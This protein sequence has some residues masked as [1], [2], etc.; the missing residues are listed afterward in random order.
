[1]KRRANISKFIFAILS[2]LI[3]ANLWGQTTSSL[4]KG[5]GG[6]YSPWL[7]ESAA[8]WEIFV[9]DVN[10]LGYNYSGKYVQLT[11]NIGTVS[12]PITSMVGVWSDKESLRKPFSGIFSGDNFILTVRYENTGE[13]TA[14]FQCTK[15]ATIKLLAVRGDIIT[16]EGYAA[17]LIGGN[18]GSKT[19]VEN[20]VMVS[21]NIT[22]GNNG[23]AGDNCA[24][25]VVDGT[26]V[27]I[28]ATVYN[29]M[30]KAN[31][32]CGGFI[33]TGSNTNP[34]YT[35]INNSLFAPAEGTEMVY[36]EN[37]VANNTYN[38]L[39]TS[40]YATQIGES[41][42]GN[43]AYASYD[44]VP[45]SGFW[46]KKTLHDGEDY[47][48][49]GEGAIVG[50]HSEYYQNN[51][52]NGGFVYTV[53]F[54]E[55]DIDAVDVDPSYYTAVIL[56]DESPIT[57]DDIRPGDYTLKITGNTGYC[58]G[59]KNAG[60]SVLRSVF[61]YGSGT[62]ADPYQI[63][64]NT[65]WNILANA[66][67]DGH[68]FDGEYLKLMNDITLTINNSVG[69]D[70][71]VG[72]SRNAS[73]GPEDK[74]F[75]GTFDGDWHTLT[76]NVGSN[77]SAYK[78][79]HQYFP[80]APFS[81]IDGATIKNLTVE[82]KIYA[83]NKYNSG[84]VGY[85]FNAK[86]S[87]A[88]Y[89]INCTSSINIDCSAIRGTNPDCSSSGFVAENKSGSI[90]FTNCIF[91][92]LIDK[93][94]LSAAQKCAGFVSYNGGSKLF[95]TNCTMA[96]I[97]TLTGNYATF[98]R[99]GSAE[100]S[101]AYYIN[102]YGGVTNCK[103]AQTDVPTNSIARIYQDLNYLVFD[104]YY[105]PG[106]IVTGFETTIYTYV[107]GQ[108]ITIDAPTVEYYGRT[109]RRGTDYVIK[110]NDVLVEGDLTISTDG[111]FDFKVEGIGDIY[112]GSQTTTIEVRNFNT[113]EKVK[114]ALADASH[115]D[116]NIILNADISPKEPAGTDVALVVNG[117]VVLDLNG[118]T[119]DR[120]LTDSVVYGQVI[121]V[122]STASLTINGPGTITGGFH[123]PGTEAVPSVNQYYDKRDGGGI[124]NRGTLV[125][126]NVDIVRNTCVKEAW[127]SES[128]SARGGGIYT[129]S[130]SSLI[131]NG[132]NIEYNEARGGGGG[133]YCDN[134]A[135]F[136]MNGVT[137]YGNTSES[138]GGGIR[139]YTSGTNVATWTDCSIWFNTA[140]A[141][142]GEGG[143]V[144]MEGGELHMTRCDIMGNQSRLRGCGFHSVKGK[145]VAKDCN[146]SY[147]GSYSTDD[148]NYGGGIC[149]N[150]TGNN[151][152]I[153]IMD[154]G[155]VE[156]NNSNNDGGGIYVYD[157][158]EFKV[159]GNVRILDNYKAS[160]EEGATPNN[161][162]LAGDAVIEV[163]GPLGDDA[164]INITPHG[165]GGLAVEFAEGAS[166][167]S[168]AEDLSH[169][170]LDNNNYNIIIDEDGNIESYEP[171][172]WNETSTWN[173]T[174]ATNSD[175]T[176]T[177]PTSESILEVHRAL[178]IP[179]G[180]VAYAGHIDID[181]FC[182]I[183]IEDG[184]ELI[185]ESKVPVLAKK[186]ILAADAE[187]AQGWYI[188]SSPVENP[189]IA[190][191]TNLITG[192]AYSPKYDLYRFNEAAEELQWEN[193]RA[194]HGDFTMLEE[195]R[196]YLYRNKEAYTIDIGGMLNAEAIKYPL[197]YSG[198][199]SLKGFNLIGNPYS[200]TIYKGADNAAIPNRRLVSAP[201]NYEVNLEDNYYVLN[202]TTGAWD[203][204]TDGT[205]I[206]P[207]TAILVQAAG[208]D[209]ILQFA[210]ST[211]GG[212]GAKESDGKGIWFT[213]AINQYEDKAYVEFREGHGLNKIA[214]E[215]EDAP[216]L[217][218]HHDDED[219]ASAD[220]NPETKAF[221]LNFEA[222]TMGRYTLSVKPQGE[223]SYLHLYDK[224]EGS[225]IDLLAKGEYSFVGLP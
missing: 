216:M 196:G 148:G 10:V 102:N 33:V 106:G 65:D 180:C 107:E 223:F 110:V 123:F 52:Q 167:G 26:Y 212:A 150:N 56:S 43:R 135:V 139:V 173:G 60:F 13:Y 28:S 141:V 27:E 152:S 23:S 208:E 147:N 47:F 210:N 98:F 49:G 61:Q 69:S 15:G 118:H 19:K 54:K 80:S 130:G 184:G 59:V 202:P 1:M 95:F 72:S 37:F 87:R 38:R 78:P 104:P 18:Y 48:V 120:N 204:T 9:N 89:I 158:A 63:D 116:R 103:Q 4:P 108:T 25:I 225:D 126:N 70:M 21:V 131:I 177:I 133:I 144:F 14:P 84:V 125:L 93:G 175:G 112:G 142:M 199:H 140:T 68:S 190:E 40:Y 222:A 183:I 192:T 44:D 198:N 207:L 111:S 129:G 138:K 113:W 11:E 96:G 39:A 201:N 162:Y 137:I 170:T 155:T 77:G 67:N 151:H 50:L 51:I 20:N 127:G 35:K 124:H 221:N 62:E 218:I 194:G 64:S 83:S 154:G 30:I 79:E 214:H 71:M 81:V 76:F 165:N 53:T 22:D 166:S 42:Q 6:Q 145:T 86:T 136:E 90:Y 41:V 101:N 73:G 197:S 121:R 82:G 34:T 128:Y 209:R 45:N 88:S 220:V 92:G 172:P 149:L 156:G 159:M 8:D 99:N 75:S 97:I 24:G 17:G 91:N 206:P 29:G 224:V 187:K 66:V 182:D 146:I 134:A 203:L 213:V 215:N 163:I 85:N 32:N 217:Y 179:S 189:S 115:G 157:G 94:S 195:G 119:I 16:T 193:Y 100:F 160:V 36:G 191:R 188:V 58:K 122:N 176:G 174:I 186:N 219:F 164:I 171:Y 114:D 109:L 5:N 143:G 161:T 153:Y 168:L 2:L 211:N 200:H 169:F 105:V 132:G 7:I 74:W 117:T 181:D 55:P 31:K 205:A 12:E 178:R 3:T 46:V 57:L 185:T